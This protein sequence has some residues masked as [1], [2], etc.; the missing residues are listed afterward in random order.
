[1][2]ATATTAGAA[3]LIGA[4]AHLAALLDGYRDLAELAG[5]RCYLWTKPKRGRPRTVWFDPSR[6][7]LHQLATD[8]VRLSAGADVYVGLAAMDLEQILH[9]AHAEDAANGRRPRGAE[10]V[11]GR[12]DC[13][14]ALLAASLDVDC[15]EPGRPTKQQALA[16]LGELPILPTLI[17]ESGGGL[18]AYHLFREPYLLTDDTDRAQ[19]AGLVRGWQAMVR[20]LWAS[21]G[22]KLDATHD[23]ARVL[24]LAGTVNLKQS[25]PRPVRLLQV[26]LERRY[27][28]SD[29]EAW[30]EETE[31]RTTPAPAADGPLDLEPYQAKKRA[32]L[33]N[34]RRAHDAY[35]RTIP[36]P[37]QDT[38]ADDA[39]LACAAARAGFTDADLARLIG[40]ARA[41]H[42]DGRKGVNYINDTIKNARQWVADHPERTAPE[43]APSTAHRPAVIS[44]AELAA[45]E[46]PELVW[47][48]DQ[49]MPQGL[50]ILAGPPKAGKSWLALAIAVA[51]ACGG[52]VLSRWRVQQGEALY[53]GL[54]DSL[55]RLKGRIGQPLAGEAMP[56]GL[57]LA[58]E[59]PHL[60]RGG[61]EALD[62]WLG[63]HP[64]CRLVVIDTLARV[65][66]SR[67]RDQDAYQADAEAVAPLQALAQRR[68]VAIVLVHHTRKRDRRAGEVDPLEAVSGTLGLTGV[69]DAVWVLRRGRFGGEGVLSV[70]GRDIGEQ[71]L[72]LR[73]ADGLWS[74]VGE[75]AE[76]ALST[77]RRAILD[78]LHTSGSM[79]LRDVAD[80]V[81]AKVTSTKRL[82]QKLAVDGLLERRPVPGTDGR[83]I[84]WSLTPEGC[85]ARG[86]TPAPTAT[87]PP[88]T[89]PPS[90]G[91]TDTGIPGTPGI[92]GTRGTHGTHPG[93]GTGGTGRVPV[94]VPMPESE[95]TQAGRG[96]ARIMGTGGTG[97]TGVPTIARNALEGTA[98]VG[99]GAGTHPVPVVPVAVRP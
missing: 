67:R 63:D 89:T 73:F 66:P 50:V 57:H 10:D 61:L 31:E 3:D 21:R 93:M 76:V 59:W 24:R 44:A 7:D 51:V 69:A 36:R 71:E 75:A 53:L 13:A 20:R 9:Q 42:H 60:D 70:M 22:W 85:T 47:V 95:R 96:F 65:R 12:N 74:Y 18:H 56:A 39:V 52:R 38:S 49:L 92:P 5:A 97:G 27:S 17:V 25:T 84:T 16:A 83:R 19:A 81:G 28:P 77:E 43:P 14:A 88:T 37:A 35:T 54:E 78:V 64:G 45:L 99:S 91:G 32:L 79:S 8:A 68:G 29:F 94:A 11:R 58:T 82:L 80:A 30:V 48:V 55:R 46:L 40:D 33:E 6:V 62:L 98:E 26:H 4:E 87:T 90:V 41:D 86:A 2:T 34:D 23:L 1:M 15:N 72:A